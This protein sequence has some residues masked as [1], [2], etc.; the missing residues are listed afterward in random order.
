MTAVKRAATGASKRAVKS[1]AKNAV[2]SAVKSAAKNGVKSTAKRAKPVV[3]KQVATKTPASDIGTAQQQADAIVAW[4]RKNANKKTRDGMARYA[5]PVDNALGVPVGVML[6]HAKSLG[7]D[8]AVADAL[9]RTGKYEAR[10]M[11]SYL[12]EPAHMTAAKMDAWVN[13]FDSWAICDTVCWH[14]FEKSP[15]AWGRIPKWARERGE[16]QKR[17]SMALLATMAL[18]IKTISDDDFVD[19]LPLIERAANDERN[20]VHKAANWALRAIGLRNERL[21]HDARELAAELAESEQSWTRWVGKD[22][23]KK[24]SKPVKSK[25]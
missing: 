9:W 20:F 23:I 2:K 8:Q 17:T 15:H 25:A 3:K 7:R 6:K 21:R 19:M 24:L 10:M 4:L 12:S 22:A 13:D 16:Y 18:H 11:A 5:I 1:A 14:A